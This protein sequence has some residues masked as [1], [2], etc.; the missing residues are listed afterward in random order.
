M[1]TYWDIV[2]RSDA[3]FAECL[4][5]TA[6]HETGVF[7]VT[8]EIHPAT[9]AV[10]YRACNF[11]NLQINQPEILGKCLLT[12]EGKWELDEYCYI[13]T[14]PKCWENYNPFCPYEFH[15]SGGFWAKCVFP[16]NLQKHT[17]CVC[18]RTYILC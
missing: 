15:Y 18:K 7:H 10:W 8:D 6:H 14:K 1:K 4:A 5:W 9:I 13:A 17:D 3:V 2:E 11:Y 16:Q 12:V